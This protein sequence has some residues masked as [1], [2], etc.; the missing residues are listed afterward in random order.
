[1]K[2]LFLTHFFS[3]SKP[4]FESASMN[5]DFIWRIW[6]TYFNVYILLLSLSEI[7]INFLVAELFKGALRFYL[8]QC[9]I[10]LL[11]SYMSY[12]LLT[13]EKR[14]C[15]TCEGKKL[16]SSGGMCLA[17]LSLCSLFLSFSFF[18]SSRKRQVCVYSCLLSGDRNWI[19]KRR[20]DI[21]SWRT[22]I[23]LD[24]TRTM[25]YFS[26]SLVFLKTTLRNWIWG[27]TPINLIHCALSYVLITYCI[28]L[29][30]NMLLLRFWSIYSIEFIFFFLIYN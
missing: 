12:F 23:F 6:D 1:M 30:Q 24:K 14:I 10:S 5:F 16:R 8:G 26:C 7:V 3:S 11:W 25:R 18:W 9:A 29:T 4:L 19:T 2:N 15:V 27:C 22:L 13:L 21:F 17:Q 28:T 20:L